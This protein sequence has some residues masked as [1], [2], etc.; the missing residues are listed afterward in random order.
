MAQEEKVGTPLGP[1]GSE[2]GNVMVTEQEAS[3]GVKLGV[4]RWVLQIST[5]LAIIGLFV[6]WAMSR[7]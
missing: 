2:H 5:G 3:Q 1:E 6:V 4:M 7:G